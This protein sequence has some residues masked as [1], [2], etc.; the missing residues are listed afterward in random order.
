MSFLE[1]RDSLWVEIAAMAEQEKLR[2]YDLCLNSSGLVVYLQ[3]ED[4][5]GADAGQCHKF[6]K[7]L[8]FFCSTQGDEYGLSEGSPL[9]VSSPGLGR[10]LRLLWHFEDAVGESVSITYVSVENEK[11][12]K[13]TV[14]G[15]LCGVHNDGASLFVSIEELSQENGSDGCGNGSEIK[16]EF[17]AISKARVVYVSP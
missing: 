6:C 4:G 3:K 14:E 16:I 10:S 2:V 15:K 8:S 7:R 12:G 1:P 13:R 17:V 11:R 9:E 5:L